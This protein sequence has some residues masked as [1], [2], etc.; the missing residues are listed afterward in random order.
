MNLKDIISSYKKGNSTEKLG[1]ISDITTLITALITVITGQLLTIKFVINEDSFIA[2][3][4]YII[5]MGIS[6]IFL[7]L[8]LK[9][10]RYLIT[11]YR[12]FLIQ[13]AT[14]LIATGGII[15][16][17]VIIWSFVLTF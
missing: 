16:V 14:I 10:I 9:A 3:A 7:F 1:I 2:I 12:S 5:A 13:I 17:M 11:E 15:F 4:F 6:L 8:Y